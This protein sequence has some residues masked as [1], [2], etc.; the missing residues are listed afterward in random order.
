MIC[1]GD[2]SSNPRGLPGSPDHPR[3]KCALRFLRPG[4]GFLTLSWIPYPFR[5]GKY[6]HPSPRT[7]SRNMTYR[8]PVSDESVLMRWMALEMG[9]INDGVVSARKR[10]SDL[11]ADPHPT[12]VTRGGAEYAFRRETISL[13]AHQLPER[14]HARLRLPIIFFFDSRVGD[15]F[16]LTDEDALTALQAL[17][18]LSGMREM[19]GGRLWVGRAIVLAIMRKYPTAVQ[20][21]M[22]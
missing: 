15:S 14:L 20:I 2:F 4:R 18:E 13:L 7:I 19:T 10:L 5:I 22:Q 1:V 8:P 17:G 21:M 9:K 16:L 3:D 12:A 11:L 6:S